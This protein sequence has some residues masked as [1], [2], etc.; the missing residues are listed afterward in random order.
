MAIKHM[1]TT[2]LSAL[3]LV[4]LPAFAGDAEKGGDHAPGHG[5]GH[6]QGMMSHMAD[7]LDLTE[8]QRTQLHEIFGRRH[9]GDP[10]TTMLAL[11]EAK[12]ELRNLIHDPASSEQQI[13]DAWA[14]VSAQEE[15]AALVQHRMVIEIDRILTAEQ[16]Q[17]AQELRD[18]HEAGEMGH[19]EKM[20]RGHD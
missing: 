9:K 19:S 11:D 7:A 8:D 17:K 13:I 20:Q 4:G 3:L 18:Q 16:R 5:S 1:L 6:S 14:Q 2:L 15:Q 12:K 10:G